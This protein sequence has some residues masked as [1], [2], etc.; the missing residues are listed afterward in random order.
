M[1]LCIPVG[2]STKNESTKMLS[3][4]VIRGYDEVKPVTGWSKVD[5]DYFFCRQ[6]RAGLRRATWSPPPAPKANQIFTMG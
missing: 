2:C 5:C 1:V 3:S 6:S 4:F